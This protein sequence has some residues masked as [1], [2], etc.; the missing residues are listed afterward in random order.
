MLILNFWLIFHRENVRSH[1]SPFAFPERIFSQDFDVFWRENT[2]FL[3][4]KIVILSDFSEAN[5]LK[6][7]VFSLILRDFLTGKKS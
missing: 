1:A 4:G 7:C 3:C 5:V 6:H 2:V